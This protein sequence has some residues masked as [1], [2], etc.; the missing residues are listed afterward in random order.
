MNWGH[1]IAI[2]FT[3]F[4][5]FMVFLVYRSFQQ[6]VDLVADDYYL[7]ELKYQERIDKLQQTKT[8]QQTVTF[9]QE[10]ENLRVQFDDRQGAVNG[11]IRF[12][13]PSDAR[14]DQQVAIALDSHS[15]QV[16]DVKSIVKG[17]YRVQVD[18]QEDDRTYFVEKLINIR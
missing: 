13:R 12:F 18:W 7:Q 11:T 9:Q 14:F 17:Y 15:Q 1:G 16:I 10:A 5:L 2:T 8:D 6:Q 3:S 4:A